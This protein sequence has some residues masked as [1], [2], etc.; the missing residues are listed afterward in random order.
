MISQNI[1]ASEIYQAIRNVVGQKSVPLHEPVFSSLEQ[2]YVQNCIESTFVSSVGEFVNKF[3]VEIC[4]YTGAKYAVATVNG[5]SALHLG[6]LVAGVTNDDEV[7]IPTLSFI[8]TANAVAYCG[9]VPHFIDSDL[10]T[11]GVDVLKLRIYLQKVAVVK[12][13]Q[14]LNRLTGRVIKAIVP[15]HTFGHPVDMDALISLASEFNLIIVEDAAESLGSY[16]RKSHTGTFGLLAALS[17]N[18]NKIITTG[19]GGA[20][21]TNNSKLAEHARHLST[22]AKIKSQLAFEHDFVGY[23]YRMPNINAALGCAQIKKMPNFIEAKRK[24]ADLYKESFSFIKGVDFFKEP[25]NCSSNY[26]L[27]TILLDDSNTSAKDF[28]ISDLNSRGIQVRPSW[29]L[30]HKLSMYKQCP[31]MDN[32]E[33]STFLEK[34]IINIPSSANLVIY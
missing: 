7:L 27:N 28:I 8:A 26:W 22:T 16:Y 13:N 19:G 11:L 10:L 20:I 6:L 32:L 25:V 15:M 5:T 34:S 3:E 1:L 17:F 30:L 24:L 18:G 31:K 2:E 23:N 14:C 12:N 21:I 29:R 9:A 4:S 33:G